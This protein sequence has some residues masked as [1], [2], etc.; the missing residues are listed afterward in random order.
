MRTLST[1]LLL[2]LAIAAAGCSAV[3]PTRLSGDPEWSVVD[4]VPVRL[5]KGE[6]DC[7]AAAVGMLLARWGKSEEG[8][9]SLARRAEAENGLRAGDLRDLARNEGLLAYVVEGTVDD[10]VAELS[11]RHPVLVGLVKVGERKAV[12]HYEIVAGMNEMKGE[13]LLVDPARGWRREPLER[14]LAEWEAAGRVALVAFPP[15]P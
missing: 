5:Q 14:F 1:A 13:V 9:V 8:C 7:G 12:S 6:A 3:N 10:L 4:D 2:G 11:L 15:Y